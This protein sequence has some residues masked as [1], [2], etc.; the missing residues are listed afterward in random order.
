MSSVPRRL[1]FIVFIVLLVAGTLFAMARS[2]SGPF[3]TPSVQP[4]S[5]LAV[6]ARLRYTSGGIPELWI[7]GPGEQT[8]KV[9]HLSP[10]EGVNDNFAWSPSRSLL[11]FETYDLEGHSPLTTSHVW[12]VR[13]DGTG[14]VAV[15]LPSPNE[16]FSTHLAEWRKD[17]ILI[18]RA[19]LLSGDASYTF[20]YATREVR[21]LSGSTT[22]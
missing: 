2:H 1:W 11:A 12:V 22:Q 19:M 8:I 13:R 6:E 7:V 3:R 17:G 16:R 5:T 14:L 18:I 9:G 10:G 21:P 4:A 20:S 15:V